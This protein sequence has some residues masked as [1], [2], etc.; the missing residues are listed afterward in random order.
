MEKRSIEETYDDFAEGAEFVT[1]E[2]YV[3]PE[4]IEDQELSRLYEYVVAAYSNYMNTIGEF[5]S[6]LD[7]KYAETK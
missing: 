3:D 5:T 2:G 6:V 4:D 7:Q 1:A